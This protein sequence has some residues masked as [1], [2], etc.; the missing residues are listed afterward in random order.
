MSIT[1]VPGIRSLRRQLV[2]IMCLVY[3]LVG[4]MTLL[5]S[6]VTQR[7]DLQ[8]QLE[9]RARSDSRI[10]AAG[11]AGLLNS[12]TSRSSTALQDLLYSLHGAEGV[13]DASIRDT[14]G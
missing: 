5:M 1:G 13:S 3:I 8:H 9:L 14:T 11:S 10:L 7:Q 6:Y 2:V 12:S 4:I